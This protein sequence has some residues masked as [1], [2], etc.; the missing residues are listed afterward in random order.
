MLTEYIRCVLPRTA[1]D[2]YEYKP[3]HPGS[4]ATRRGYR[5]ILR[6]IS[7]DGQTTAEAFGVGGWMPTLTPEPYADLDDMMRAARNCRNGY[8]VFVVSDVNHNGTAFGDSGNLAFRAHHDAIHI[9]H[10]AGFDLRGEALACQAQLQRL[11]LGVEARAVLI[12]E[13]VGQALFH[14]ETGEFPTHQGVQPTFHV[15]EHSIRYCES[16]LRFALESEAT[17]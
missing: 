4:D 3:N 13:V 16:L 9:L 2:G 10:C 17:K 7:V 12:G 15:D 1:S 11:H 6:A 5:D 14:R 8:D